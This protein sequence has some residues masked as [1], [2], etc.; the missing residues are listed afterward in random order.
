MCEKER[1]GLESGRE[2]GREGEREKTKKKKK[3]KQRYGSSVCVHTARFVN[4]M[5]TYDLQVESIFWLLNAV[6]PSKV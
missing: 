2:R 4:M 1:G 6:A 3:K 5:I